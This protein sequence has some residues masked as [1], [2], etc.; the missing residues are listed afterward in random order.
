MAKWSVCV[1]HNTVVLGLSPALA[2]CWIRSQLSEFKPSA[3]LVNAN[4]L[5]S[6]SWGF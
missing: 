1:T 4:W 3:M 2:T 5:P 6:A